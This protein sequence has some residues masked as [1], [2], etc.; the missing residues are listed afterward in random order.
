LL[1]LICAVGLGGGLYLASALVLDV[2][3]IRSAL[4]SRYVVFRARGRA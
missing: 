1:G 2:G 4:H 3:Q